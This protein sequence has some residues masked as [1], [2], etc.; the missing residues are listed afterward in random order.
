MKTIVVATDFST[1]GRNAVNYA[2]GFAAMINAELLLFHVY[3]L[4]VVY[5]EIPVALDEQKLALDAEKNLIRME[6][7]LL[8]EN[9]NQTIKT[10]VRTGEFFTELQAFCDIIKPYVVVMGSQGSTATDRFIFGGHSVYAMKHLNWPLI[11]V[12]PEAQ[13]ATV[14][15]IGLAC[16]FDN[17]MGTVPIDLIWDL[18]NDIHAELHVIN[19]GKKDHID[20]RTLQES[21]LLQKM[22]R[23]L[24]PQYHMITADDIDQGIMDFAVQNRIDLLII[25]PKRHGLLDKLVHASHTRQ[26]VLKSQVPVMALHR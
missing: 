21:H 2:A 4:P 10:A 19:T 17:V 8:K 22:L 26:L 13:F 23:E 1:A 25:L 7:Q 9:K 18:V 14:K 6:K 12:P 20:P 3:Q 16:D 24:N 5:Y 15:C 11:T